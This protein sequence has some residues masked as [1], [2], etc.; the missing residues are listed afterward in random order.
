MISSA[1]I[2][3]V[4]RGDRE[5]LIQAVKGALDNPIESCVDFICALE[6]SDHGSRYIPEWMRM[7]SIEE[8]VAEIVD[9]DWEEAEREQAKWCNKPCGCQEPCDAGDYGI[10]SV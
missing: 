10:D 7:S 3:Q 1:D 4:R 8:R 2:H 5:G 9:T 6:L